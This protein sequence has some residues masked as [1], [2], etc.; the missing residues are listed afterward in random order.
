MES[1]S[2]SVEQLLQL[3]FVWTLTFQITAQR[4]LKKKRDDASICAL[5]QNTVCAA[6]LLAKGLQISSA[7]VKLIFP[8]ERES[9]R[10]LLQKTNK[11][12]EQI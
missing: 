8:K 5:I 2:W 1:A 11:R 6:I 10:S 3:K 12:S 9:S 4:P 7:I